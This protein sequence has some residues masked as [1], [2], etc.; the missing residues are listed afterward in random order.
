M[1]TLHIYILVDY[2][3]A[4]LLSSY[5]PGSISSNGSTDTDYGGADQSDT[6][7]S[8]CEGNLNTFEPR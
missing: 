5:R 8:T 4:D 1:F 6:L 3:F 7:C 2:W